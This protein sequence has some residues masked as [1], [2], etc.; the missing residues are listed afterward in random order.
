MRTDGQNAN[1]SGRID[2][3]HSSAPHYPFQAGK[4]APLQNGFVGVNAV[5]GSDGLGRVVGR[6]NLQSQ[7]PDE[8]L[9]VDFTVLRR[10][11][12]EL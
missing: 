11:P 7:L 6:K 1:S 8:A 3:L 12:A 10:H 2:E 5:G 4:V 9:R